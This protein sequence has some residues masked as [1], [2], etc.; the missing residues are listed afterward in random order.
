MGFLDYA[1]SL[2]LQKDDMK[3]GI[4]IDQKIHRPI[5]LQ[6]FSG[7]KIILPA[8]VISGN[9]N[10]EKKVTFIGYNYSAD[11]LGIEKIGRILSW[12]ERDLEYFQIIFLPP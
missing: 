3:A 4:Q 7:F 8:P 5:L 2:S 6:E 1:W 11:N 9:E 12:K 10:E